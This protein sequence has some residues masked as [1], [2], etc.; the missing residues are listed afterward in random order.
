MEQRSK[1]LDISWR[2]LKSEMVWIFTGPTCHRKV[3]IHN[4]G[5]TSVPI[6]QTGC[7]C[8]LYGQ[9]TSESTPNR[10]GANSV[11]WIPS[12]LYKTVGQSILGISSLT[13]MISINP[14]PYPIFWDSPA[15]KGVAD[16]SNNVQP[17]NAAKNPAAP[18]VHSLAVF[19]WI[20]GWLPKSPISVSCL[21]HALEQYCAM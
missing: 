20:N 14:N 21:C 10:S 18:N 15:K 3:A 1:K 17:M 13:I 7:W 4:E 2:F 5:S 12:V 19:P 6:C 8:K 11:G 16:L 9:T